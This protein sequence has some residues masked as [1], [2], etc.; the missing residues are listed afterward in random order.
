MITRKGGYPLRHHGIFLIITQVRS[1]GPR[2]ATDQSAR[3]PS[4]K[5]QHDIGRKIVGGVLLMS[6]YRHAEHVEYSMSDLMQSHEDK[7]S[8]SGV[9]RCYSGGCGFMW[10]RIQNVLQQL[11]TDQDGRLKV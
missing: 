9:R 4:A 7:L 6:K 10:N 3:L 5:L 11:V 1:P 2:R 8:N